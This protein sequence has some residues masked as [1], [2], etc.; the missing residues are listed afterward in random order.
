MVLF[1]ASAFSQDQGGQRPAALWAGKT[2]HFYLSDYFLEGQKTATK[3]TPATAPRPTK[4]K[5]R[6]NHLLC[7]LSRN[8]DTKETH[9]G[10]ATSLP[11]PG[12]NRHQKIERVAP[13]RIITS[14]E[15]GHDTAPRPVASVW[16]ARRPPPL[17]LWRAFLVL[18]PL[19]PRGWP[20]RRWRRR[21]R[22]SI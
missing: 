6:R 8:Y 18:S 5:R 13:K 12:E 1:E 17:F 16:V 21:A 22:T 15:A 14:N 4:P 2:C 9:Q 20:P 19:P 11:A 10:K 3:T 7:S